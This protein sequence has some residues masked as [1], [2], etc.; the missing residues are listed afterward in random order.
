[1]A[2]EERIDAGTEEDLEPV[3]GEAKRSLPWLPI[4]VGVGAVLMGGGVGAAVVGPAVAGGPEETPP[5]V[6]EQQ[7]A[8]PEH[9]VPHIGAVLEFDNLIVNP[10]GSDGLRFLMATVGVGVADEKIQEELHEFDVPLRDRITSVLE[11]QTLEMLTAPG[12]REALKVLIAEVVAPFLEG[13][14]GFEIYI[15]H[16]V[17]Q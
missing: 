10:A 13:H 16:F 5:V 1:M 7:H 2:D 6:E 11:G 8:E 12:A 17:I 3:E 9:T 14:S 15:P 4:A